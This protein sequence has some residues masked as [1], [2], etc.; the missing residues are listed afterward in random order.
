M[1]KIEGITTI[2][3]DCD[4]TIWI[5]RK[6][7]IEIILANM[8]NIPE[9]ELFTRQYFGFF[10]EFEKRFKEQKFSYRKVVALIEERLPILS[11]YGIS[12]VDFL[13]KWIQVETSFLNEDALEVIKRQKE[14]GYKVVILTDWFWDSQ[15]KLLSKY[16]VLEYVDKIYTCDDG[17]VKSNP[18]SA[19]KIVEKGCESEYVI[20]GDSLTSDIAFA[21]HAR[22]RSIWYNWKGLENKTQYRP[23]AEISEITEVLKIIE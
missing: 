16:G 14:E 10:E 9:V 22:I 21:T 23:T 2:I 20:I 1:R 7:E 15:I 8:V 19:E 18:K 4:D 5:H 12:A 13:D 11:D 6:D 17:F 3:W